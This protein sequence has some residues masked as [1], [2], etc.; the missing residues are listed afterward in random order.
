[1]AFLFSIRSSPQARTTLIQFIELEDQQ[2]RKAKKKKNTSR[3]DLCIAHCD[4]RN[5]LKFQMIEFDFKS[6]N[7]AKNISTIE[8]FVCGWCGMCINNNWFHAPSS[9]TFSSIE[10][11]RF[12]ISTSNSYSDCQMNNTKSTDSPFRISVFIHWK[13]VLW[14]N[15]LAIQFYFILI[16]FFL[17]TLSL[18][19][20][21][22][23]SI[24]FR[25]I[26]STVVQWMFK[27]NCIHMKV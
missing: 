16:Y 20:F 15:S 7:N 18:L 5:K 26:S 3:L 6:K 19:Y 12:E 14:L 8:L 21:I 23:Y 27:M 24:H 11:I 17:D 4:K 2:Q 9:L 1:M 10:T 25:S 22:K 13:D